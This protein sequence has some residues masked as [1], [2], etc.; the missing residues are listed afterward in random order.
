MMNTL[1][2]TLLEMILYSNASYL[3][4]VM[5]CFYPFTMFLLKY[6]VLFSYPYN[7]TQACRKRVINNNN[8]YIKHI[9]NTE[10]IRHKKNEQQ[11]Y[12]MKNRIVKH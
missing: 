2:G 1:D 10:G 11:G 7:D 12:F 3:S 4:I 5:H 6:V 9:L 8:S